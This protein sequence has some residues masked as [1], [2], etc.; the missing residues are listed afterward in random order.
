MAG[1]RVVADPLPALPFGVPEIL[2]A[3]AG[4]GRVLDVGC[5]SGRLTVALALAG[6][7]V[8]GLD[9]SRQRL[10]DASRRASEAGVRLKLLRADM[11]ERLPF[12]DASFDGVA[13]RLALMIAVDPLATLRELG[14]VLEP[15][16]RVA[17]VVWASLPE[18]PWFDAPRE[19][20]R[21]TL[22]EERASFASAFGKLG[23]AETAA[24]VHTTAG[25]EDVE[26]GYLREHVRRRDAAEHWQR[27]ASE[28]GHFRRIEASLDEEQRGRLIAEVEARLEPHRVGE[29]FEMPRTLVLVTARRP[30]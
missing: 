11:E 16:G 18:N 20:V 1:R 26:A 3:L 14:R 17:I 2:A 30:A 29:H 4:A 9:S 23:D 24:D 28:N 13:S 21:A 5:G 12:A 19:A 15:G 6:A 8:T 27:L 7:S 10:D 22:G 25:F